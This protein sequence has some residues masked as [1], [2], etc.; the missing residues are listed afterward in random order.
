MSRINFSYSRVLLTYEDGSTFGTCSIY[1]AAG[2]IDRKD[3]KV[4]SV[5]VGDYGTTRLIDA[6][7][8][9]WV[10]DNNRRGVMSLIATCAFATAEGADA[11]INK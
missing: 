10:I 1:C 5:Q 6:R 3:K 4:K 11:Y 2:E 7:S 8:A 9:V